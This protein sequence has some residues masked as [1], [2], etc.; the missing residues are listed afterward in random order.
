MPRV[1]PEAS[2]EAAARHLFRHLNDASMLRGNPLLRAFFI[3]ATGSPEAILGKVHA[4]AVAIADGLC[5]ELE[6]KGLVREARR[7]REIVAAL[8]AGEDPV[9]TA[10]RLHVS[11]SHYYRERRAICIEVARA[12]GRAG[13]TGDARFVVRDDPLRLLFKRAETL[14]DAGFS[15]AAVGVLNDA[16]GCIEGACAKATVGLALAEELVFLGNHDRA[17]ELL[18]HSEDRNTQTWAIDA[19]EWLRE[20]QLL[21]R[22]R[23]QSQ[24]SRDSGGGSALETLAK[25]RIAQRRSD[26]VT[27][28]AVFL[29]GEWYQNAGRFGE[30][31][32]MLRR[33]QAMDPTYLQAV[34]KRQIG[35]FLLAAYCAG[36]SGDELDL[37]EKYFRDALELSLSGGTLVGALLATSGLIAHGA[38]RGR[39]ETAYAMAHDALRMAKGVD[40]NGFLGYVLVEIARAVLRTRY[41]RAVDPLV[42]EL[43]ALAAPRALGRAL[44]KQA[45]GTLLKRTGRSREAH[46]AL[47]EGLALAKDLGNRRLEGLMLRDRA[48]ALAGSNVDRER[49]DAMREAVELVERYGSH[50][51]LAATYDAAARVLGDRR[52]LR[53]ARHAGATVMDGRAAYDTVRVEPLRLV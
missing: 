14:R 26:D 45:Q 15:R 24:L 47:S 25:R 38:A 34:P 17:R 18:A 5:A 46:E 44:L 19:N 50:S 31:K 49:A 43:E 3:G 27:Y 52:I 23:L 10:A 30:A 39:D 21:Y 48:L 22:A 42:F 53:Q 33:L 7:R 4:Q 12:F 37:T 1:N 40:F 11:R 8:C 29:S 16:Y 6:R 13:T 32:A 2:F 36:A 20:T 28:D 41:W 51:D 35:V 9:R